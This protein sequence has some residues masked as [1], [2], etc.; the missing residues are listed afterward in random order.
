MRTLRPILRCAL[1][2]ALLCSPRPARAV[3]VASESFAYPVGALAGQAGGTGWSGAWITGQPNVFVVQA[4]SLASGLPATGGALYFDGSR[5]VA[6]T[7]A[8]VFRA[9]D[10]SPASAAAVAGLVEN[11]STLF[12]GTQPALG[13]PGTTVWLGLVFNGGTAGNGLG[14]TQYLDQIHLYNGATTT[15]AMLGQGDNNKDGEALAIG[16]G[17]LNTTWNYERTCAHDRCPGG[18]TGSTGYL[19][20]VTFDSATHWLVLR[21]DFVS[22]ATT[23]V[24]TW[25]DP[26]PGPNAP[27]NAGALLMGGLA[28]VPVAGLHF[29]WVELG[30]QTSTFA[31]DE[32][33]LA[34]TFA[35]LSF[36]GT[37]GVA[38]G[39]LAAVTRLSVGPSPFRSEVTVRFSLPAALPTEVRVVDVAGRRVR[40]L[41]SGPLPAGEHALAW[42]GRD[43]QGAPVPAGLYLVRVR[44]GDRERVVRVLHV[45]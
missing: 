25:L 8:R 39:P 24:T 6:G 23:Q 14:G 31:F 5:A 7:G 33:R 30:G 2:A 11:T 17:N 19:S 44:S 13:V 29:N 20:T 43:A 35:E 12:Q 36:G 42:D 9:I 40:T 28:V 4:A 22:S 41:A 26:A 1:L 38:A 16:R 18:A 27:G 10:V 3:L 37:L 15:A 21:F 32:L 45:R 34:G